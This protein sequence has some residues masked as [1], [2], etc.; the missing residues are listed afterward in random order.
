LNSGI[1]PNFL[2]SIQEVQQANTNGSAGTKDAGSTTIIQPAL[3][4][5]APTK[6]AKKKIACLSY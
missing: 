5:K 3:H 4:Y 2:I 6:L 1:K